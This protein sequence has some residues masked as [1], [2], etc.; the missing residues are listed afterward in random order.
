MH[1]PIGF[2]TML[3]AV[4]LASGSGAP[5]GGGFAAHD[6][7]QRIGGAGVVH[8]RSAILGGDG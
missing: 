6:A 1:T 7:D 3:A 2:L 8:L 4:D 5:L